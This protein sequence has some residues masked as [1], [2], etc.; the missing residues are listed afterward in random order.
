MDDSSVVSPAR[1][2]TYAEV[3]K[4]SKAL[5]KKMTGMPLTKVLYFDLM[6][7]QLLNQNLQAHN[8]T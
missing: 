7:F 8:N 1:P 6:S 4:M 3:L 2:K 5:P